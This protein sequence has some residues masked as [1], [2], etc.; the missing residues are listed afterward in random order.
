M[1]IYSDN[2]TNFVGTKNFSELDQG[3][4][5]NFAT[6]ERFEWVFITPRALNFG[7]TWEAAVKSAKK[8]L[9]NVTHGVTLSL[10]EYG[11]LLARVVTALN[12]RPICYKDVPKQGTKSSHPR[13]F[14]DW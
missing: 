10:E 5:I 8:Y 11:T 9:L 6:N 1:R 2:E 13:S 14:F 4:V 3:K 12:S 7:G